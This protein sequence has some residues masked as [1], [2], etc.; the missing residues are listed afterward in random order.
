MCK[1]AG[2]SGRA[3]DEKR[4]LD[5]LPREFGALRAYLTMPDVQNALKL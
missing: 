1:Q 5:V 4:L 3:E 2:A